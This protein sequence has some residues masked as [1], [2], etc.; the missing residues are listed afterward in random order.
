MVDPYKCITGNDTTVN[1]RVLI[2][3]YNQATNSRISGSYSAMGWFDDKGA[4]TLAIFDNYTGANINIHLWSR[5]MISKRQIKDA[6]R[7]VFDYLKC[8]RM[9]GIFSETNKNLLRLIER[10]DFV[11]ECTMKGYFGDAN[12]PENALVY[13]ISRNKAL[14][15]IK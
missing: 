11:Y 7:Y 14:E 12:N 5:G 10:F 6:Y 1:G 13:Y 8:N 3:I 9:T 4:I 15:W 2:S